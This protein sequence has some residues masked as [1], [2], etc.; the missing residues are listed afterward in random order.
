DERQAH[1]TRLKAAYERVVSVAT[2]AVREELPEYGLKNVRSR[3]LN[4]YRQYEGGDRRPPPDRG[5]TRQ[6]PPPAGIAALPGERRP[7]FRGGP[8]EIRLLRHGLLPHSGGQQDGGDPGGRGRPGVHRFRRARTLTD[9]PGRGEDHPGR[10]A[11][12]RR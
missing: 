10:R 9:A 8:H 3:V 1:H 6:G 7:P 12:T 2:D 5:G 11:G 4:D